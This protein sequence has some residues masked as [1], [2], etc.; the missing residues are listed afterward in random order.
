M[1][2]SDQPAHTFSTKPA[3]L[4]LETLTP[5]S[6]GHHSN[7]TN[8]YKPSERVWK[9]AAV[10]PC[11]NRRADLEI[12]LK[13]VARQELKGI[14]LWCLVVDNASTQP[15]STIACPEGLEVEFLRL[16]KNSGG[17][18]GF[19]AGM[20]HVVSGAGLTGV[21]GKPDFVWWLDSDA[22][23]GR[24]CLIELV[25]VLATRPK[26]GAVGSAMGD[27][28][29]GHTW[30]VGGNINPRHG[31]V[32]PAGGGDL[33]R[34]YLVR[35]TYIAA[36]SGLVRREAIEETGLFP[37]NFIYYDD[38]DWCIHMTAKTGLKC[39]GAPRSRAYHP[40][41]NRRF[42]SW[43]RYYIARNCFSHID[44]MEMGGWKRFRRGW[45]EVLKATAQAMMGLPELSELHLKGLADARD[46]KFPSI[47][48]KN[49]LPSI[50]F[51]PFSELKSLVSEAG[52]Q[53]S[54][55]PETLYVAPL[56]KTLIPGLHIF[57][58]ELAK[59][60]FEWP[61]DRRLWRPRSHRKALM[62]DVAAAM[63][64][65]LTGPSAEVAIVP[66]GWP[67][68]WFRGRTLIEVTSE[69]LLVRKVKPW[70]ATR[71]A[72]SVFLRGLRLCAQVALR[73]PHVV[74]LPPA[75]AYRPAALS[76]KH[77]PAAAAV[78]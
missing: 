53:A 48:P 61:E 34:R 31:G 2:S 77:M 50:G 43:A 47:E 30:E 66:T 41:G 21:Y 28:T 70:K 40:P 67:A 12:L 56:L 60:E 26:I 54:N 5:A 63:W 4:G 6:N 15:L 11:F 37:E 32:W 62:V 55:K 33:D 38:V 1:L 74:P 36:C 69:G 13:D 10:I 3:I 44:L 18:G 72:A 9:V 27:I 46:K 45:R 76:A 73:G 7:G 75:P 49:L 25:K 14:K 52:G 42:V 57:R 19:N 23:A 24:R 58:K 78:S 8:G 16:E 59:V 20:S 39:V 35:S 51:R 22:R 65:L 71:E 64:R 17:S 29:T 68:N